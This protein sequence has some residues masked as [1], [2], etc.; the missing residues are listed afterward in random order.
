MLEA[1]ILNQMKIFWLESLIEKQ[2]T[3]YKKIA[4]I[5]QIEKL[6]RGFGCN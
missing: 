6:K 1:D 2:E 5:S 4:I 3:S